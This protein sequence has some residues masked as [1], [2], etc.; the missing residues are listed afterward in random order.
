MC[1]C[2]IDHLHAQ[3]IVSSW[4]ESRLQGNTPEALGEHPNPVCD[5]DSNG[6]DGQIEKDASGNVHTRQERKNRGHDN[7][8]EAGGDDGKNGVGGS[9]EHR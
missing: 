4:K 2:A 8:H 3:A 5:G 1:A 7:H 9:K 6:H